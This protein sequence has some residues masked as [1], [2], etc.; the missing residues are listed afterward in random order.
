MKKL[1]EKILLEDYMKEI[2]QREPHNHEIIE[3]MEYFDGKK[4]LQ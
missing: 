3:R 2:L 1:N 4:S